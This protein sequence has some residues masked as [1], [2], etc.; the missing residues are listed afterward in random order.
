MKRLNPEQIKASKPDMGMN[1]VLAG[2]G[3]GKTSTMIA[4]IKNVIQG[5]VINPENIVILTF[6]RKAAEEIKERLSKE[7]SIAVKP[8]F[9]GTFHAFS[10]KMLLQWEDIY[11][12]FK[13]FKFF[14]SLIDKDQKELI[15]KQLI[16]DKPELF[17]GLPSDVVLKFLENITYL[18]DPVVKKI[19]SSGLYSEIL[20]LKSRFQNYKKDNHLLE[21]EDMIDH[22]CELIENNP[23]LRIKII[24]QFR[25]IFVDEFQDT[26]LNNFRL[27][28]QILPDTDGNIFL[29]G[30]DYQSI[31]KFRHARVDYIINAKK[32][33]PDIKI[34]KLTINYRSRKEITTLADRFIKLNH[35][36]TSKKIRSIKGSGGKV[37]FHHA[38]D[39]NHES[40]II[41]SIL[42]DIDNSSTVAVLYRNNYQGELLKKTICYQNLNLNIKFMTMH[43]SKG[44]EFK[45]VII[46]GISDKIIPDK[47]SDLEEERRLFY[48]ALTRAE[49]EL[50]LIYYKN[51]NGSIPK[52]MK[53]IRLKEE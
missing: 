8:G 11:L 28:Q 7:S 34:H 30:D 5:S 15:I 16:M 10:L 31:Y 52:F 44:L 12:E 27:L 19:K 25:Y 6:S 49:E 46:A 13:R 39:I 1:L 26:S 41:N 9:A 2:A 22:L 51:N 18:S 36:R 23:K 17:L 38:N 32:Y 14:P 47:T 3:T 33:F 21:F 45:T 43:G 50:H 29:V 42:L 40:E 35:F 4:K 37:I 20:N 48:V 24:E 53:E